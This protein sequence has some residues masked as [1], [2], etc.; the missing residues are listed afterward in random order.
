MRLSR[1]EWGAGDKV[2]VLVHGMLGSAQQLHELG[3]ALADRGYRAI[4]V[5]LPGHGGSS[6]TIDPTI[7]SYAESVAET[8]RAEQ[9]TVPRGTPGAAIDLAIGHSLGAIVLAAALPVLRPARAVYVDVPFSSA[10]K[11]ADADDL[12]G[13]FSAAKAGRTVEQLRASKPA[14]SEEDRKV[15]AEAARRFDPATAVALQLAYNRD[16]LP[17]PPGTDIPSMLIRAEPSRFVSPERARELEGLGFGVR[18]IAGAGHCAWYG[19]VD[20]FL[21]VVF[22]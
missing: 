10:A 1:L 15:E 20:E 14:W 21:G 6:A 16:P 5:D 18:S 12:L 2:A 11:G 22:G 7:E 8:V 17:G 3:P 19:R 4:A 13:R 9:N